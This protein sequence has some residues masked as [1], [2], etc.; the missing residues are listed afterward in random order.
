MKN[1]IVLAL[2]IMVSV[3]G[4]SL[5]PS[6]V[7]IEKNDAGQVRMPEEVKKAQEGQATILGG[8]TI[9]EGSFSTVVFDEEGVYYATLSNGSNETGKWE[10]RGDDLILTSN[11]DPDFSYEFKVQT[12]TGDQAEMLVDDVV[13]IWT[14]NK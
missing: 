1:L 4:C 5:R 3:L 6:V 14:K 12:L 8:W 13:Q 10:M 11:S 2:V 7:E 9:V